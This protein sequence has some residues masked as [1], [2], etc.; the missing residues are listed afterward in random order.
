[1]AI[2]SATRPPGPGAAGSGPAGP[3][4]ARPGRRLTPYLLLSPGLLW[5][6]VFFVA[7]LF[8]LAGTSTQTPAPSGEIGA[9]QQTFRFSNYVEALQ[10][11]GPQSAGRS[12]TRSW[13]PC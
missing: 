2:I 10:G 4:S 6:A 9:F 7:P 1:M 5:L 12:S 8:T 13:P 11:Y 3:P